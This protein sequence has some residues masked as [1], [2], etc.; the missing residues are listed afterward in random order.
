MSSPV[1]IRRRLT[2]LAAVG[3][4]AAWIA[5]AAPGGAAQPPGLPPGL[6]PTEVNV[7]N[8][9]THRWG[10][11]Q[12]AVS[13]KN[14]NNLVYFVMSDML[15]YAC[16]NAGDP[17]CT[18]SMGRPNGLFNV[19]GWIDAGVFVSFDRGRTWSN[20]DFPGQVPGKA[21]LEWK[22][23]PMVTATADG[24]FYI[25]WDALHLSNDVS[26][27]YGCIAVSKSTDGGRTWSD[28]VCT[29]TPTDRPWLEADLST[30]TLYEVSSGFLGPISEADP[31]AP[32]G[33]VSDRWLVASQDGV[34]WTTPQRLGGG[35]VPG[36]SGASSSRIVAANGVLA[37]T[38]RSTSGP[39]CTFFVG[40]G[41]PCTVF[42]TTTDAGATWT[43]HPVPVPT[44]STGQIMLAADPTTPGRYTVAVLNSTAGQFLV[45]RTSDSG[46][47]WSG[48]TVVTE[49]ATKTHQR[50]WM[51]SSPDGVIGLMWRTNQPGAGP[52][53]PYNI[54]A[55][56][57]DDGGATFSAPIQISTANSP[58]PDPAYLGSDDFSYITLSHQDA[59]I[60]WADWRPGDRTGYFSAVKLQA[61]SH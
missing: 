52:T 2:W 1:R 54:W 24:T 46:T 57:S 29:G 22:G 13:P 58:A 44:N 48:P 14:P 33:P 28:P 36:F 61:F 26:Q 35:G 37:A 56:T 49:D 23:D 18:V 20:V 27:I 47:T 55:A 42:Q 3:V 38:F 50:P 40:A 45:Y 5:I 4:V 17:N 34:N 43:R 9:A 53:F 25:A 59:F 51:A 41:A 31:T 19:P 30:G 7:T 11:P 12:I 21:P 32:Q 60:G 10:E 8:D 39:A 16:E 15:T 6:Q